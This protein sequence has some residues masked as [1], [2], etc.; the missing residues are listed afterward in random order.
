MEITTGYRYLPT[1]PSWHANVISESST[2]QWKSPST[3]NQT[4]FHLSYGTTLS[5][6]NS[7]YHRH[8][9]FYFDRS[10]SF[11]IRTNLLLPFLNHFAAHLGLSAIETGDLVASILSL[12]VGSYREVLIRVANAGADVG[13][14]DLWMAP[15]PRTRLTF[16]PLAPLGIKRVG[17]LWK[18]YK[19]LKHRGYSHCGRKW[20]ADDVREVAKMAL[21]E[22]G[23][24]GDWEAGS[25]SRQFEVTELSVVHMKWKYW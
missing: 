11:C 4:T 3:S 25:S 23:G 20:V 14:R 24:E 18:G 2:L 1:E 19:D 9:H 22:A 7:P 12:P 10:Q 13:S 15:G 21:G 17:V 16:R 5:T 6:E 8:P